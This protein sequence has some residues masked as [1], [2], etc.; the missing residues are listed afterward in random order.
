LREQLVD[1]PYFGREVVIVDVKGEEAA[2][3]AW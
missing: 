2:D 1:K 3:V